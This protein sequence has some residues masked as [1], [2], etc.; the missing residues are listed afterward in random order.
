M[1]YKNYYK[2]T[3][4]L[5]AMKLVLS[6]LNDILF[7]SKQKVGTYILF[8]SENY[9]FRVEFNGYKNSMMKFSAAW[10]FVFRLFHIDCYI[11]SE[12]A[13]VEVKLY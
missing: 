4:V 1:N 7:D 10:G 8:D 2:N 3:E 11:N 6:R 9:T 5:Y 12:I 13:W